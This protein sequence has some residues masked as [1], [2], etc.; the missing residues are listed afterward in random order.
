MIG[1][2]MKCCPCAT[3]GK[4][5]GRSCCVLTTLNGGW[6][7]SPACL[8]VSPGFSAPWFSFL[9]G[10]GGLVLHV[11]STLQIGMRLD[12]THCDAP[13]IFPWRPLWCADLCIFA[14]RRQAVARA[15]VSNGVAQTYAK[16][17]PMMRLVFQSA[18]A[19]SSR[20]DQTL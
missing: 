6:R 14:K 17:V 19:T 8:C 10:D 12:A 20:Q 2:C 15:N 9:A 11:L 3:S 16:L 13:T 4:R 7:V 5:H 18:E 1:A